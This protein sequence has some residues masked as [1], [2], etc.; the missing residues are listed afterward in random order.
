MSK[1]ITGARTELGEHARRIEI[2]NI[3]VDKIRVAIV[4]AF[5]W[6]MSWMA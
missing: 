6:P 5:R 2:I 3:P 4:A 1:A